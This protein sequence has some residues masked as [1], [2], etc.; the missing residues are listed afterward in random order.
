MINDQ[1]A[2]MNL[3]TFYKY[4]SPL[5]LKR[6]KV[7]SRRKNHDTGIRADAP[8]K[9]LHADMT[10]FK[11]EDHQKGYIYLIQDNFSRA[12]LGHR[13]S[14]KRKAIHTLENI[15]QV[16]QEYLLPSK[17][18][19]SMLLTDD[20]SENYGEAKKWI[21]QNDNPKINHVV[22]QVDIHFS[23]SMIEAANKQ[24]KYRFLYNHKITNYEQLLN[25]LPLAIK[26]FNNRPHHVLG[27]LSPLEVLKG[28]RLNVELEKSL[29]Q[30]ARKSRVIENQKLKSCSNN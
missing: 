16:T 30:S 21:L 5:N 3:S 22:A 23:N 26:D 1:V 25:Y 13:V 6:S 4:V 12:I 18:S 29:I 24:L 7:F 8:F 11:T 10:E 20:G 19:E 27:G 15:H 28:K 2:H 9:I 14:D 17:I